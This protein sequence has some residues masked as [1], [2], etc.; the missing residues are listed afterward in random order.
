MYSGNG[1]AGNGVS[2]EEPPHPTIHAPSTKTT[3]HDALSM[4]A[5]YGRSVAEATDVIGGSLVFSQAVQAGTL[6]H[7]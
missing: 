7:Q 3:D 4:G 1:S 2:L 5:A 6:R